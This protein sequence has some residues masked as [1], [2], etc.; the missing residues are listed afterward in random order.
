M[1]RTTTKH[2][3]S[4]I[5]QVNKMTNSPMESYAKGEDGNYHAQVG[6]YHLSAAY[7]GVNMERICND[8]GGIT[9]PIGGGYHTKK[10]LYARIRA[11]IAG[12]EAK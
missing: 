2:L 12:L 3:Q 9:Q 1:K 11:F 7:G 8:G 6:N 5:N 10:E 4:L